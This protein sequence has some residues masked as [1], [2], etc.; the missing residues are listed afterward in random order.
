[1]K[2]SANAGVVMVFYFIIVFSMSTLVGTRCYFFEIGLGGDAGGLAM[3]KVA[4]IVNFVQNI[5][6]NDYEIF[7]KRYQ[8]LDAR[9]CHNCLG[10]AN[11]TM[12]NPP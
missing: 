9:T 4:I 12:V 7:S 2:K 10:L 1:M 8:H 6:L 11:L 5:F 3:V